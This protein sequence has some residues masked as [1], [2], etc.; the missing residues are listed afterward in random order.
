MHPQLRKSYV[1][2]SC[3]SLVV[4]WPRLSIDSQEY[5]CILNRCPL[6]LWSVK[7]FYSRMTRRN[8]LQYL[9]H[10]QG[11]VKVVVPRRS[12]CQ[13]SFWILLHLG[14]LPSLYQEYHGNCTPSY[15]LLIQ[16]FSL[17]HYSFLSSRVVA[18]Q[19]MDNNFILSVLDLES[20]F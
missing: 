5:V 6:L 13:P 14:V 20:S 12:K 7:P 1:L 18:W 8:K 4:F 10:I 17:H 3:P 15:E 2:L 9:I 11:W 19:L 16:W